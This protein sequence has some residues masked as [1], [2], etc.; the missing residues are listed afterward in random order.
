MERTI[1]LEVQ[2]L[3]ANHFFMGCAVVNET[4][5]TTCQSSDRLR[6]SHRL[7]VHQSRH[8]PAALPP[9]MAADFFLLRRLTVT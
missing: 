9:M 8:P 1:S 2:L 4:R 5:S 6:P 7:P 3:F